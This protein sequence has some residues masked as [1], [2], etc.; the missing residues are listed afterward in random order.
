MSGPKL[1]D[2]AVSTTPAAAAAGVLQSA[3]RTEQPRRNPRVRARAC[4]R[5]RRGFYAHLL[6][7][8]YT[9]RVLRDDAQVTHLKQL[10]REYFLRMTEGRLDAEYFE[11]RLRVGDVHQRID[12]HPEWY[13]GTY[14]L[15]LRL[16]MERLQLHYTRDP[17]RLVSLIAS[18]SKVI[19]LDMGL[20]STPTS[21]RLRPSRAGAGVPPHRR[22]RRTHVAREGSRR[23]HEGRSSNM[24]VH[25][26]KG[27]LGGILTV[28][29]LALRKRG[30]VADARRVTSSRSSAAP[31]ISCA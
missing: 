23:A 16:V 27:P 5:N 26:L 25:D 8:E 18:L 4:R 31:A 3:T 6:K 22:G 15:Y 2:Q 20:H 9:R 11:S 17:E 10:Q 30:A 28:T 24:I 12:L 1:L 21:W 7:F 13:L 14:N 19:F 29:Q